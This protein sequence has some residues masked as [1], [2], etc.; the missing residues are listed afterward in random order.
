MQ[1]NLLKNFKSRPAKWVP[2]SLAR[3]EGWGGGVWPTLGC[4]VQDL[5][6]VCQDTL[7]LLL[8]SLRPLRLNTA[9]TRDKKY[10]Q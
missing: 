9:T 1:I 6:K 10:A 8:L 3:M 5:G 2:A 4:G 7:D